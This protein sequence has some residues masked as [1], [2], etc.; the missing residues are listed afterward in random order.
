MR[1]LLTRGALALLAALI[2][3]T[4]AQAAFPD[5]AQ[6]GGW[7]GSPFIRITSDGHLQPG[8]TAVKDLGAAAKLWRNIYCSNLTA[9]NQTFTTPTVSGALTVGG[10]IV[11]N[12]TINSTGL[13]TLDNATVNG[14]VNATAN[15]SVGQIFALGRTVINSTNTTLS[16]NTSYVALVNMSGNH[17]LTLPT[18]AAAGTGAVIIVTDELTSIGTTGNLLVNVTSGGNVNNIN[19]YTVTNTSGA[20][21]NVSQIQC[22]S[23]GSKWSLAVLRR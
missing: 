3:L 4:A 2:T 15:V 9:T 12:T 20:T 7:G 8:T 1:T 13:A 5:L 21:G 17:T 18:A 14:S 22:I 10:A 16:G 6:W 11:G 23:N 19:E